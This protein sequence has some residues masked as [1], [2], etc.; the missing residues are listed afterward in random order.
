MLWTIIK[1][2]WVK[3]LTLKAFI[4]IC[5]PLFIVSFFFHHPVVCYLLFVVA[6]SAFDSYG[7]GLT[8]D[9]DADLSENRIMYRVIQNAFEVILLAWFYQIAGW[10]PVAASLIAHWFTT[11]DK[12]FYILRQAPDY[13]GEYTWLEGWSIFL[14]LKFIGIKPT[15][16]WIFDLFAVLGFLGGLAICVL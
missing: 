11:C 16:T 5:L 6:F 1:N 3:D 10:R 7:F 4:L 15:K 14:L 2:L 8:Q 9:R 13:S 12:L